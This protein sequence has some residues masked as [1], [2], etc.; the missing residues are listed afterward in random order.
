MRKRNIWRRPLVEAAVISTIILGLF[1]FWFGLANRYVLFLYG[2]TA[3]NIAT[4]QPF[5]SH[6]ASRHWMAGLVAAGI[7]LVLYTAAHWLAGRIA[8]RRGLRYAPPD[9]WRTWLLCVPLLG[10]GIPLIVM[11]VNTP[12][13]PAGLAAACAAATLAGLALALLPGRWAAQRPTDLVWLVIDG[14]GLILI[15]VLLRAIELPD[16]GL[17]VRPIVA[18][19]FAIGSVIVGVVWLAIISGLRQWGGYAIPGAATLFLSGLAQSY[20][21]MPLVHYLTAG[22]RGFRYISNSANFFATN[23]WLQLL[24]MAVAM[25]L[26]LA[27]TWFRRRLA[28]RDK[29]RA[30]PVPPVGAE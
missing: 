14:W 15:L 28:R 27:A 13:L 24:A 16:R 22:P 20:V 25:G 18:W 2:H 7:V 10:L 6:T 17:S 1:I 23:L 3:N 21:L 12:T 5:D 30:E 4:T 26:A 11:S 8:A 29:S 9:W 19:S